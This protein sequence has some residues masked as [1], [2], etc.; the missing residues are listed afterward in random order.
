MEMHRSREVNLLIRRC[1]PRLLPRACRSQEV[2]SNLE[3]MDKGYRKR[4][5]GEQAV[6]S[7]FLNR[8]CL[9]V[10]EVRMVTRGNLAYL[11][12]LDLG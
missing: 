9:T 5:L 11:T 8:M 1:K 2:Y 12:I 10:G 7:L 6:A 4:I 3:V